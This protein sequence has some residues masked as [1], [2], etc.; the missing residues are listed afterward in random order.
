MSESFDFSRKTFLKTTAAA[1]LAVAA[2]G[3]LPKWA[4]PAATAQTQPKAGMNILFIMVDEMRTPYVYMPRTLQ[5]AVVPTI[6]KLGDDG[7]RFTNYFASSNCCTPARASQ[8]TGL[9]THQIAIFGT[10]EESNLN[11]GFPT[12][13]TMLRQQG[14]ETQWFGKWHVTPSNVTTA[15]NVNGC[16]PNPYEA[17]GFTVPD[18][19][20]G[21]CP[22]PDGGGGQGQ[23]MDPVTRQQFRDWIAVRPAN[24]TPWFTTVSLINPHDIQFYPLA[25][26][27]VQ[28]EQFPR[29][30]YADLPDNYET[31]QQRKL[32]RKPD[33]YNGVVEISNESFGHLPDKTSDKTKKN[34]VKM[35]DTYALLQNMVD[36]QIFS[37]L[38]ALD[39]SPHADN[40]VV[41]FV[42]DHGEYS[43]A[44]GLRGKGYGAYDEG[45]HIPL[46]VKDPSGTWIK[47]TKTDRHQMFSS[48]D[49]AALFMTIAT[50]NEAWRNDSRYA[51]I[52]GRASIAATLTNP[53]AAGR[54]YIAHATDEEAILPEQI[55]G[56][57]DAVPYDA[58]NHVAM[59]RTK[60]GKIARFAYWKDGGYQI[61][62]SKE[63][64][65]ECYDY[66]TRGGR[67][68]LDNIYQSPDHRDFVAVMKKVLDVG[69]RTE[70][71]ETLPASLQATQQAA[72][73]T[74]FGD[75][76]TSPPTLPVRP[77]QFS[78]TNT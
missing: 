22:S 68:E 12:Y 17:Y 13:G 41:V 43:G 62:P 46:I 6:T 26:R 33:L 24:G 25:T 15:G 65:W 64:Q 69:M 59:V 56:T 29:A 60:L 54:R 2:A 11:A 63:I 7:A 30:L 4:M 49:L 21:T 37:V 57:S 45:L 75:A 52:A 73:V 74:W 77:G 9:Y 66:R 28:G 27:R 78:L 71:R 18:P 34:W 72:F 36:I 8:I 20:S 61:D 14:Y 31:A 39:A 51:Q 53:K 32:R 70:V 1:G 5:R 76:T 55:S 40:T 38:K 19:A 47:D 50:G 23:F 58:P 67:L 48:V 35:L 44:H 16:M 10:T 42:S 3:A